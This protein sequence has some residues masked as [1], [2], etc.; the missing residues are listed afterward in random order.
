MTDKGI[1][2]SEVTLS[3]GATE[4]KVE[5]VTSKTEQE[6]KRCRETIQRATR[7]LSGKAKEKFKVIRVKHL[8]ELGEKNG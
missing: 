5:C 1:Y 6:S 2:L 7:H 3:D 8:K 4:I